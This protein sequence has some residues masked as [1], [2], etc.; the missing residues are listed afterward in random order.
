METGLIVSILLIPFILLLNKELSY[1]FYV[2]DVGGQRNVVVHFYF[3]SQNLLLHLHHFLLGI[4]LKKTKFLLKLIYYIALLKMLLEKLIGENY[5][6]ETGQMI[7]K[8][9]C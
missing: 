2:Q 4:S 3:H 8:N 6:I 7:Q 9:Q 1:L 5:K